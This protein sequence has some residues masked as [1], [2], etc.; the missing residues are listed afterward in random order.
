MKA[1]RFL[2]ALFAAWLIALLPAIAGAGQACEE[3]ESTPEDL[4]RSFEL[5]LETHQALD[6]SGAKIAILARAGQDLSR[7]GLSWSHAGIA[8]RDHPSG[9]WI[10]THLLNQCGTPTSALFEEGLANFFADVPVRWEALVII[11]PADMQEGMATALAGDTP[12]RLHEPAYNMVAYPFATRYQNSNQWLL[13]VLA[14]PL[15]GH[16]FQ[17]RAEAQNWL[18][19]NG[20]R[21]TALTIPALA[22]LGGRMFRANIAFDD[23]PPEQR[24]AGHID[25]VSVESVAAFFTSKGAT[26]LR[27][28]PKPGSS[29]MAF[30]ATALK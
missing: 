7:W 29:G 21:A 2:L 8:W 5:A 10:V 27:L 15:A 23:H 20:Y 18:K 17:N 1:R 6:A 30:A 9:K 16:P 14:E 13:E 11:P 22:R 4:R 3:Q 28:A 24:W 12:L 26:R 25:T 19:D